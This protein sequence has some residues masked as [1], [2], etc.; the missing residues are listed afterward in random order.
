MREFLFAL[1]I[2]L[3]VAVGII[4]LLAAQDEII[5]TVT[6]PDF[7]EGQLRPDLFDAFEAEHPGVKVITEGSTTYPYFASPA[8]VGLDTHLEEVEGYASS[9]DVLFVS[10]DGLAV[11]TTRA[12]YFL[13]LTPLA[14]SDSALNIEDFHPAAWQSFAWDQGMWALPS[15]LDLITLHYIPKAFD[16]AG[17]TYPNPSWTQ[18]DLFN[19]AQA[20][21]QYDEDGNIETPGLMMMGAFP[22]LARAFTG[23]GFYDSSVYPEVPDLD[24]PALVELIETWME[25]EEAAL[26]SID[27]ALVPMR[28]LNSFDLASN[29]VRDVDVQGALLPGGLAGMDVTGYAVSAGTLHPELAY[30][31]AKYL[32]ADAQVNN[33]TGLRPARQSLVGADTPEGGFARQEFSPENA[34]FLEDALAHALPVSELRYSSYLHDALN[35]V[36]TGGEA[37]G[38]ALQSVMSEATANLEAAAAH[39]EAVTVMVTTPVPTPALAPGESAV[40][41]AIVGESMW[42]DQLTRWSDLIDEF[43]A[44]DPEVGQVIFE[45]NVMMNPNAFD[46]L[47]ADFDCFTLPYNAVNTDLPDVLN[48]DPFLDADPSFDRGDMLAG[49][50]TQVTLDNK[51]WALPIAI[52]PEIL[53]YDTAAF[54]AAGVPPPVEGWTPET[55]VDA[56][57]RLKLNPDDPPPVQTLPY[58]NHVL[59]LAAAFGGLP[60]DTRTTP[61]TLN[62]TDPQTVEAIRQ[63]LDLARDGYIKYDGLSITARSGLG[64]PERR[65]GAI[66][67]SLLQADFLPQGMGVIENTYLP[68][69]YPKGSS[70]SLATYQVRAAYISAS[71]TNPEACYR[72]LSLVSKTPGLISGMPARRSVLDDPAS[73][74]LLGEE[75]IDFYRRYDAYLSESETVVL[76]YGGGP[77]ADFFEKQWL[78]AAFD[79]YVLEDAELDAALAEAQMTVEAYRE[80]TSAIPSPDAAG[81]QVQEYYDQFTDCALKVDPSLGSFFGKPD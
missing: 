18:D 57:H 26:Y 29:Y 39:R 81:A 41:F 80:C 61:S 75:K 5:L 13:D 21:T 71:A 30:E 40:R 46:T 42:E 14:S 9:G 53:Y 31:L 4:P 28:I 63:V 25:P 52:I 67:V 48:L 54:E 8:V 59:S 15:T 65:Q 68:T 62:F 22:L 73:A 38:V 55:F 79:R 43:V 76:N 19:A 12:G 44:Q 66:L 24:K 64:S 70:A 34:A 10:A 36:Q 27:P 16:E 35:R 3:L 17:L 20:L 58:T 69:T 60:I 37:P 2:V 7:I 11:E 72:W 23:E 56:L 33:I 50:L 78:F 32:T 77:I 47:T 49:A 45:Y 74:A 6:V 1:L 51:V